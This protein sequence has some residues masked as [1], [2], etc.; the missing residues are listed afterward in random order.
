MPGKIKVGGEYCEI[1]PKKK[2]WWKRFFESLED[3]RGKMGACV[4]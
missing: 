1:P 3:S 2:P 4:A